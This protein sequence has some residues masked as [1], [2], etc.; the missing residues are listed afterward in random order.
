MHGTELEGL[1]P[2]P[3]PMTKNLL[4]IAVRVLL[5]QKANTIVNEL[6]VAAAIGNPV[7]ALRSE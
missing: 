1:L 6:Y 5:K 3:Y 7:K 2:N 4:L